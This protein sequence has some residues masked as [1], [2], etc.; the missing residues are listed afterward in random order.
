MME[1]GETQKSVHGNKFHAVFLCSVD[2]MSQVR[3]FG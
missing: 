2:L 1:W 3:Q